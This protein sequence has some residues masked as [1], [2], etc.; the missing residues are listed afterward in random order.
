V[1]VHQAFTRFVIA[2]VALLWA[3]M[4][5]GM[6]ER[7]ESAAAQEA[8]TAT[9]PSEARPAATNPATAPAT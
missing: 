5:M 3:S 2:I 4:W 6:G 1:H 8:P 9:T 7:R